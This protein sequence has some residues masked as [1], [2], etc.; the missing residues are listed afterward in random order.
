MIRMV[1]DLMSFVWYPSDDSKYRPLGVLLGR[2]YYVSEGLI[3]WGDDIIEDKIFRLKRYLYRRWP[4]PDVVVSPSLAAVWVLA[5]H[6]LTEEYEF[7]EHLTDFYE[8]ATRQFED[9][10]TAGKQYLFDVAFSTVMPDHYVLSGDKKALDLIERFD[11]GQR[12]DI[13]RFGASY[14]N[15]WYGFIEGVIELHLMY[16]FENNLVKNKLMKPNP[17]NVY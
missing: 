2:R 16:T 12:R 17:W 7:P 1:D 5:K 10:Y 3:A 6:M 15:F 13:L 11:S 9:A 8:G 4:E 14:D